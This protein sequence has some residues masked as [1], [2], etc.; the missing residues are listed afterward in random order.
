MITHGERFDLSSKEFFHGDAVR[1]F[2]CQGSGNKK[3]VDG[4]F[5]LRPKPV[6]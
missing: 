5:E 2:L 4:I 6:N 3:G 1:E